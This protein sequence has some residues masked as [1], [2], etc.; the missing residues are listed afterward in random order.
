MFLAS[1]SGMLGRSSTVFGFM[2]AHRRFGYLISNALGR[3]GEMEVNISKDDILPR[4]I[5]Y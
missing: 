4:G 2:C 5:H 1:K 3:Y